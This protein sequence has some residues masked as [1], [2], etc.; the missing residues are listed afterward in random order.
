VLLPGT[1]VIFKMVA[2]PMTPCEAVER[3]RVTLPCKFVRR[4][5]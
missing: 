2:L 4:I 1:M 3:E 5:H